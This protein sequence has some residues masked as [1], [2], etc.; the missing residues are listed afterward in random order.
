MNFKKV[1]LI[2]GGFSN[3]REV[4]L[5]AAGDIQRAL[6]EK[7]YEV[8]VYDWRDTWNLLEI[9]KSEK[10]DAVFN[11]LYGN[12]GEDGEIQGLLDCLQIPYTHSGALTSALGMNKYFTKLA[13]KACGIKVAEDELLSYGEFKRRGVK[14]KMPYVIKPVADGSSAGVFIVEDSKSEKKVSYDNDEVM[15]LAERYIA[16]QELTAMCLD[17][18][19]YVV[20]ELVTENKFYDYQAKYTDGITHHRLPADISDEVRDVCLDY[21]VKIHNALECNGISRTD[22][23]YNPDDGVVMLEINTNP[24]M[25]SLS[26]VPEQAKYALGMSYAELCDKLVR[27]AKCRKL[28]K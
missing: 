6:C 26:L 23:R 4:S 20:T 17:G 1:L 13:A 12:W 5:S 3:E 27:N 16:G 21:A 2:V 14:L 8:I 18:K 24:G 22:F 11:G 10:P 19:A 28:P 7:G 25:T 9:I 15:L